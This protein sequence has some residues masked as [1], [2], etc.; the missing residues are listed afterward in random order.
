MFELAHA[1]QYW[2]SIIVHA[3]CSCAATYGFGPVINDSG[4]SACLVEPSLFAAI[5]NAIRFQLSSM[6]NNNNRRAWP[7]FQVD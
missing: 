4:T 2:Q 1:K 3:K 7:T 5:L 6:H